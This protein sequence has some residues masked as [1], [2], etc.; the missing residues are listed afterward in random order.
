MIPRRIISNNAGLC[1][2]ITRATRDKPGFMHLNQRKNNGMYASMIEKTIAIKSLAHF[3]EIHSD[4]AV[5]V[6]RKSKYKC[7]FFQ[8]DAKMRKM[9]SRRRLRPSLRKFS[10]S[11]T[12]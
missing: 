10:I 2:E 9:S 4:E 8:F 5:S 3:V 6:S 12:G 1:N 11:R 7:R